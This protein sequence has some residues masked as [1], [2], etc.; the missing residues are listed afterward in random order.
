VSAPVVGVV[1]PCFNQGRYAAECVASLHSQTWR[2]WRAVLIDDASTDESPALVDALRSSQVAVAHLPRNLGR[3][4]VRNEAVRQL[5]SVDYVLVLDCDDRL[6]PSYV[7]QLVDRLEANPGAGLAYGT[8]EYFGAGLWDERW[9]KEPFDF[10][11]R[12]LDNRIPGPGVV[13]RASALA[14]TEG[15]RQ[16]FTRHSGE[17]WDIWLQVVEKGWDVIWVRDAI[18]EYRQHSE[19]FLARSPV[20][21]RMIQDLLLLRLHSK[22][23]E[24]SSGRKAFLRPRVLP[25]LTAAIRRADLRQVVSI[26][27]RLL[28]HAPSASLSLLVQHY[29]ERLRAMLNR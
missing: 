12:Y 19:S 6:T 1:I 29:S 9:P 18:Y 16:E 28:I 24:A 7:K 2:G 8:L 10:A 20:E 22:A 23:I 11:L 3:S 26:G 21:T 4:L 25:A 5:G 14:Q 13:F 17:D 15:W 27:L